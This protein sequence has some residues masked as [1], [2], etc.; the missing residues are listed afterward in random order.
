MAQHNGKGRGIVLPVV[1]HKRC[2]AK[3]PCV[4][5]CPVDVFE[6]RKIEPKDYDALGFFG[7][8][9][10]RAHGRK[11]AYAVRADLC[12]ACGLCVSACPERAIKLIRIDRKAGDAVTI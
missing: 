6:I 2:E 10:N 9:K 1:N 5:A 11:V 7:K 4:Q 12:E 3:G 8:L